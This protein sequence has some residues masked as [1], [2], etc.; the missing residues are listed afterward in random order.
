MDKTPSPSKNCKALTGKGMSLISQPLPRRCCSSMSP[1]PKPDSADANLAHHCAVESQPHCTELS[2][3]EPLRF[4]RRLKVRERHAHCLEH[5]LPIFFIS[6]LIDYREFRKSFLERCRNHY[7][8]ADLCRSGCTV[9]R[10]EFHREIGCF[11]FFL[12]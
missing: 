7:E 8:L 10:H 4:I 2:R 11:P 12:L 1:L 6:L 9:T 3:I 5:R